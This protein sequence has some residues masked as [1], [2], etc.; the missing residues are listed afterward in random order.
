MRDDVIDDGAGLDD[1][2]PTDMGGTQ[3]NHAKARLIEVPL[4]FIF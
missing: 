4:I 1:A 3:L 2:G